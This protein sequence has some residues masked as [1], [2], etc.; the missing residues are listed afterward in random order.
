MKLRKLMVAGATAGLITGLAACGG[1]DSGGIAS[2]SGAKYISGPITAFGSVYVNGVR[3]NTD[4]ATVYV[5][6]NMASESELRVGMMVTVRESSNGSAAEIH[7]NDDLEGFVISNDIATDGTLNVMGQTVVVDSNTV[8]ES[9]VEGVTTADQIAVGNIVEVT[10]SSAGTGKIAATRLEVKAV[11]LTAYLVDHP[12]GVEV[13]GMVASHDASSETFSIGGL[14][15]SYAGAVLDDLPNGISDGIYVE[16]TSVE[17]LNSANQLVAVKVEL[18]NGGI[19]G[20]HGEKD[21]EVEVAGEVSEVSDSSVTVNGYTFLLDANTEYDDGVLAD[22]VIG[23]M[24]KVEGHFNSNGEL[25]AEEVEFKDHNPE[26]EREMKGSVVS[27]DRTDINAGIIVI[28][29]DGVAA[30]IT[31]LINN[32]TIMHDS[33]THHEMSFNLSMLAVDDLVEVHLV[34]NGDGTYTV[35]KLEREMAAGSAPM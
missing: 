4:N 8:F 22:L 2:V 7:Y 24:V 29:V 26:L 6:N 11:D 25:V 17:D 30:D 3:Y 20:H 12:S 5:E 19:K 16:V 10:G 35:R 13:K 1:G 31:I 32:D 18:K 27:I 9:H 34:D 28:V 23:V 14:E 21:D 15:I 33:S